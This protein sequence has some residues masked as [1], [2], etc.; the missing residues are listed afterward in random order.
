[1]KLTIKNI[2]T[3]KEAEIELSGLTVIAGENDSGK[4]TVGKLMFSIVKAISK[5]EDELEEGKEYKILKTIERIYFYNRRH[6]FGKSEFKELFHPKYF[7]NEINQHGVKA[8]TSRVEFLEKH[9]LS[10]S[11][12]DSLF[13][14]LEKTITENEDENTAKM[15]AFIKVINSEFSGIISN[16][17]IKQDAHV[18]IT[19]SEETILAIK[20]KYEEFEEDTLYEFN[21]QDEL[22]FN[23]STI[24][25]T[26]MLLNF[27]ESIRESKTAFES[28]ITHNRRLG[29]AKIAFH[30]KDL[31]M[32]LRD[33]ANNDY[34]YKP[35]DV[36]KKAKNTI[37]GTIKYRPQS[38]DFF[39]FKDNG[40][41]HRMINV[42][43]GIKAFGMLQMLLVG[44]FINE[45]SLIILDE[46]EVHL[47]P[48]WQLKFAELV[49]LL[50]KNGANILVTTH[51][52]YMVE[53]LERYTEKYKVEANFYLAKDG[54]IKSENNNDTLIK[55]FK[56]LSE[57]FAVFQDL[58]AQNL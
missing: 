31:E 33:S 2:G 27:H 23:D 12:T 41:E 14:I 42:A 24:I 20:V 3:I 26:P 22:Y 5:Y 39:Y 4:S 36:Y 48:N 35:N 29:R 15:N 37:K 52:P 50:V 43:S 56:K 8:M 45:R 57:P 32:K 7:A 47:H 18:K 25:E 30:I 46:P 51:S 1:M 16:Q 6:F 40:Q 49:T 38:N 53:A 11:R 54:V 28:R 44:E 10:N 9:N 55:T 19:E 34:F 58:K 13:Q 21:Q 17:N